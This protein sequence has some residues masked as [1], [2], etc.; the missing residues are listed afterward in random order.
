MRWPFHN[1]AQAN[2]WLK[3]FGIYALVEACIQLLFNYLL[4]HFRH[5]PISNPEFHVIMWVF[6]CICIWPIWW[7]AYAVHKKKTI[8]QVIVNILFFAVYSYIWLG[9]LQDVIRFLHQQWQGASRPVAEQITTPVDSLFTFYYQLLKHA[10]RLSW[11]FIANYFYSY[12]KEE[13]QRLHLAMANKELELKLLRWHLNPDFYFKTINHLQSLSAISPVGCTKS[14][15]QLAKVMEYVIYETR[16][17]MI[18]VSKEINFLQNYIQLIGQQPDQQTRIS[19]SSQTAPAA[20]KIAPLLLAGFVDKIAS[21]DHRT[22]KG[23]YDLQIQFSDNNML[24]LVKGDFSKHATGFF[25]QEDDA[26]Y[27]RFSELYKDKFSYQLSP[28]KDLFELNMKLDE[29]S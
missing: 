10:F 24:F 13:A 21:E 4:N 25:G 27:K 29:L 7:V 26:L 15:L 22:H 1:R 23:N 18:N 19:F 20:L 8:T 5:E 6:Q 11:F 28:Q 3:V 2:Y 9:P 17:K 14:I 16:E 12:K